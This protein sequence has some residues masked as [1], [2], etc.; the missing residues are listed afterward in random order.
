MSCDAR[1]SR[2]APAPPSR[3]RRRL[4]ALSGMT[5]RFGTVQ[6]LDD[7]SVAFAAGEVH[8][9]LGENGAGKSTLCN[10]IFGVHPAD[11]GEMRFD[12]APYGRPARRRRWPRASPW[13][14]SISASCPN[15]PSSTT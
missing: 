1:P 12:G 2:P 5:K 4:L 9:L 3:P 8:C 13:C 10:L 15:L 11:A 7:V 6:A 14:T